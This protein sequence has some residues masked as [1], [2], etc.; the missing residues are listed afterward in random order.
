[1]KLEKWT[2]K[3]N[4][5]LDEMLESKNVR[6]C[7]LDDGVV[8]CDDSGTWCMFAPGS[9]VL[10]ARGDD[11]RRNDRIKNVWKKYVDESDAVLTHGVKGF[12][13]DNGKKAACTRFPVMNM[14]GTFS[15]DSVYVYDRVLNKFPKS[16]LFYAS[17]PLAPVLCGIWDN[18]RLHIIG[19][20]YP[21]IKKN[22]FIEREA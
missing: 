19:M 10:S 7:N 17:A 9:V 1:M 6:F 18:D 16:T 5:K 4:K 11:A 20:V 14:D 15:N 22:E 13:D 2:E 8:F 21:F 3:A 12:T